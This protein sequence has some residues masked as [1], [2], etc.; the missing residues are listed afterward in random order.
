MNELCDRVFGLINK[1][2]TCG[3]YRITNTLNGK[4]YVGQSVD[5]ASRWKSHCKCGLGIDAPATNLLYNAMQEDKIWNFTFELLEECPREQLNEKEA[6]W[7][8]TY[9]SNNYGY[10]VQKGTKV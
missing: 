4:C 1:K 10:N 7:I 8:Q 2:T 5:I 6:F 3:I 9:Q